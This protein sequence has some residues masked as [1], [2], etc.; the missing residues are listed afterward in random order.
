[1]QAATLFVVSQ[2]FE[3]VES[4]EE[5]EGFLERDKNLVEALRKFG[6]TEDF[7]LDRYFLTDDISEFSV[8][9]SKEIK[10]STYSPAMSIRILS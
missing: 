2:V 6:C 7:V 3:K 10:V 1:M 4:L 9:D 8:V 5:L